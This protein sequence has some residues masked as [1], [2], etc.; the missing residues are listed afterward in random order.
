MLKI[1]GDGLGVAVQILYPSGL[2]NQGSGRSPKVNTTQDWSQQL[3]SEQVPPT[4]SQHIT[5]R[6]W[7]ESEQ[8]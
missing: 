6:I 2:K 4:C 1:S 8:T 7:P 3:Q 5:F